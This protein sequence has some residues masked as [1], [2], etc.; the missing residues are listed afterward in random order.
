MSNVMRWGILG[1]AKFAREH[2]APAMMLAKNTELSALAT[3]SKEKSIPLLQLKSDLKV[4]GS[5]ESLIEDDCIDAVYIPLPNHLHVEWAKKAADAGKHVLCEK[6]IAMHASEID[7]LITLRDEKKVLIAEAY[8]IVHHPQWSFAKQIVASGEIG[9]IRQIDTIFS[10]NN[11]ADASNIRNRSET[12]GGSLPDIGVYTLGAARYI[13]NKEFDA[14]DH[15][16]I[17]FENNVDVWSGVSAR[18]GKVRF[19]GITSMRMSPRQSVHIQGTKGVVSLT[20]PFNP[21]VYAQAEVHISR[22][23]L[24]V[25]TKRFPA[26]NHYVQQLENFQKSVCEGADY[27]CSL[28]FSRGTQAAIDTI[29]QISKSGSQF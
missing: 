25:E 24:S 9:Q 23:N 26:T 18:F 20:A 7:E 17:E 1:S 22:P 13:M 12:G 2:M 19:R 11:A 8:M 16:D 15:V 6:P 4:F 28:E 29:F 21:S 10:Y 3:S 14:F 27:P 5:Y